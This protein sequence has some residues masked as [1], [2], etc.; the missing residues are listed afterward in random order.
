MHNMKKVV[1]LLP[2]LLPLAQPAWPADDLVTSQLVDEARNWQQKDRDDLAADVL[3]KLL[4]INPGHPEALVRLA[5]IEARA[6]NLREAEA[7]YERAVKL[8]PAP[9][10]LPEVQA[11][12]AEKK[13]IP[14][15][16][17]NIESPRP[18]AVRPKVEPKVEAKVEHRAEP[19]PER[20]RSDAG[21]PKAETR[22]EAPQP[23]QAADAPK[24]QAKAETE[25]AKPKAKPEPETEQR[26]QNK[27]ARATK[28]DKREEGK[29]DSRAVKT[30]TAKGAVKADAAKPQEDDVLVDTPSSDQAWAERRQ[31]L[32]EQARKSPGDAKVLFSLARHLTQ[33]DATRREALRQLGYLSG[34]GYSHRDMKQVWRQALLAIDGH[35]SDQPLYAAYLSAYPNDATVG[36]RMRGLPGDSSLALGASTSLSAPAGVQQQVSVPTEASFEG[37]NKSKAAV[38][39]RQALDD[40]RQGTY[41]NAASKLENALLLD[42]ATPAIRISLARQYERLGA[43]DNAG[44]LLDD[45]LVV[46]PNMADALHARARVHAAQ[47][48]FDDALMTFERIPA[49]ARTAAMAQDQR[50]IWLSVQTARARYFYRIGELKQSQTLMERAEA[51]AR[52]N[53]AMLA[54]VAAG[55]NDAGQPAQGLR[56]MREILSRSPVQTASTRVKYAELLLNNFQ[57]T[58]LSAVLR[59][60]SAPGKLNRQQQEEVNGIILSYSIRLAETLRESGQLAQATAILAPIMQRS[61]DNRL[62]V[63]MARIH[64]SAAEPAQALS[65]IEQAIERQPRDLEQ[66]LIAVDLALAVRDNDKADLHARTA[67]ELAPRHPRALSA[68]GRVAKALGQVDKA[69]D[70]FRRAHAGEQSADAFSGTPPQMQLRLVNNAY[71]IPAPARAPGQAPAAPSLLPIPDVGPAGGRPAPGLLT[72]PDAGAAQP[73]LQPA[74]PARDLPA[75]PA[76]QPARSRAPTSVLAPEK[77]LAKE[78]ATIR[79]RIETQK[80]GALPAP[81]TPR[82]QASL[83]GHDMQ[84]VSYTYGSQMTAVASAA[85]APAAAALPEDDSLKLRMSTFLRMPGA[86]KWRSL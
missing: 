81:T 59:D 5:G 80:P 21:K 41:R 34:K 15:A 30:I 57:D 48:R 31:R 83:Y 60:L 65:V 20:A 9:R 58:E 56:L 79:T 52:G 47:Q 51:E 67:I 82:V 32:E 68:A 8:S 84:Q 1:L 85:P 27:S 42:P 77:P 62:L 35:T 14:L 4:R 17:K 74:Q 40:E 75:A 69:I 61:E 50:K 19:Q 2:L 44:N 11:L 38:L 37:G 33:R 54:T 39:L 13:G 36:A 46:N 3:R 6:G 16:K 49:E 63:T 45:M 24:A 53:D 64:R 73:S 28:D 86:K 71:D 55:W 70:F 22:A 18:E 29:S 12:I 76:R 10:G 7:L 72:I 43:Y 23:K 25:S 78:E 26:E 66:R